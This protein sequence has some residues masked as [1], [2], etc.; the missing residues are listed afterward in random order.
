MN[1]RCRLE[2]VQCGKTDVQQNQIG[3]PQLGLLNSFC[4][5]RRLIYDLEFRPV[6][7]NL[8]DELSKRLEIIY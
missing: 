2:A 7:Q 6:L 1:L 4:P 8:D 3:L 5:I